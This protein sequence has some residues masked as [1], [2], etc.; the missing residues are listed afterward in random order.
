MGVIIT[1]SWQAERLQHSHLGS[2]ISFIPYFFKSPCNEMVV[3]LFRLHS[4]VPFFFSLL[5]YYPMYL[6]LYL[7]PRLKLCALAICILSVMTR[8]AVFWPIFIHPEECS[9][10][11]TLICV[12]LISI[13]ITLIL[14]ENKINWWDLMSS[15]S[16]ALLLVLWLKT[17]KEHY[18]KNLLFY[19]ASLALRVVK[20]SSQ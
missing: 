18:S 20:M 14:L 15:L 13:I 9:Y 11:M 4:P 5:K 3:K 8:V 6:V 2:P 7:N 16:V 12:I 10:C 19:F 1:C 17:L